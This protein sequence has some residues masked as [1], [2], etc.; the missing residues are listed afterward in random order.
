M[1]SLVLARLVFSVACYGISLGRLTTQ[2][3]TTF[4]DMQGP[5]FQLMGFYECWE[6]QTH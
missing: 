6:Q 4:R 5:A 3:K 1:T 2:M